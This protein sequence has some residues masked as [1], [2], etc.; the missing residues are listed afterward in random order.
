MLGK[1]VG[2]KG[3]RGRGGDVK[4]EPGKKRYEVDVAQPVASP[5]LKLRE[6]SSA[7]QQKS[8]QFDLHPLLGKTSVQKLE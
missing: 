7:S 3:P 4:A 6:T 1:D 8:L 2:V 5:S